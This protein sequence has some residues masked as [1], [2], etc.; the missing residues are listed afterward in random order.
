MAVRQADESV[1]QQR[2]DTGLS[3]CAEPV[4]PDGGEALPVDRVQ[5]PM[6]GFGSAPRPELERPGPMP[7]VRRSLGEERPAVPALGIRRN[8]RLRLTRPR[9]GSALRVI[10]RSEE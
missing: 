5:N 2:L 7:E 1:S 4:A 3:S 8:R 9:Q 10:D 6:P